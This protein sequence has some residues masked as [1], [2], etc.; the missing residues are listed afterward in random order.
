M[1]AMSHELRTPL[2]VSIGYL[3]L[4][5]DGFGGTLS[6]TQREALEVVDHQTRTLEK[7]IINVLSSARTEAGKL[8]LDVTTAS[9]DDTLAHVRAYVDQPNRD[10][11][12]E[13]G[14][15]VDSD[16]PPLTI[17]HLKVE[18]ILQ[19]LIGNAYKFTSTGRIS[20][21]I[22]NRPQD[23]SVEFTV[24]DTGIGM[25]PEQLERIFEEFYQ[26]GPAHLGARTGLGLGL[27]IVKRYVDLMGGSLQVTSKPGAG[28]QF[29][30]TLP[31]SLTQ[32][33]HEPA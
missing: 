10:K 28:T 9:I 20:I 14:W 16:I 32:T 5:L 12:V 2:N 31:H 15:E 7:L 29:T 33:M 27:S 3:G 22:R 6:D 24:A 8:R 21:R 23:E 13:V 18:E 1:N 19:N 11:R 4:L 17:D 26:I 25:E 30:F